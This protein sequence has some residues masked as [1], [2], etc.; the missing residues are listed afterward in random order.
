MRHLIL[1]FALA[2]WTVG[3]GRPADSTAATADK[4]TMADV[5]L[6][7][8]NT[9][10]NVRDR[11]GDA[12]TPINQG[13]GQDDINTTATIRKRVVE[14]PL[15]L[16]AHNIKIITRDGKVTLRGPVKTAE[17]K[18]LIESIAAEVGGAQ[19]VTSMLEVERD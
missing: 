10:V 7:P 2:A 16:N 6:D 19:N 4:T 3:C 13:Q 1:F 8:D 18:Q 9:G 14:Q 12:P 15:S 5:Q 11:T 17:E